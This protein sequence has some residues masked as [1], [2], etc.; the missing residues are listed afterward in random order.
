LIDLEGHNNK[1]SLRTA[2]QKNER[3]FSRIV[4][5]AEKAVS[6][7]MGVTIKWGVNLN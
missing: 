3:R 1:T 6:K 5:G 2:S 7:H 4:L